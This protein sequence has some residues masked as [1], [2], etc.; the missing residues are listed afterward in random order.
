LIAK[1]ATARALGAGQMRFCSTAFRLRV[2]QRRAPAGD[3][4]T[5]TAIWSLSAMRPGLRISMV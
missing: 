3:V 4:I 2:S 1:E 5:V